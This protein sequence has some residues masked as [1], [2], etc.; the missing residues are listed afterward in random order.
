VTP[1]AVVDV[2][3][4]DF[5]D[6]ASTRRAA[7]DIDDRFA[8]VDVLIN[9]AG[10]HTMSQRTTVDGLPEMIA[11]N[12]LAPWLFTGTVL[13]A[14][15]RADAARVVTVASEASRRHGTLRIP[16]DLIN[17]EPFNALQSSQLYGKTKL[18]DIMFSLELATLLAD[19]AISAMC[20]NPG[21]NTTGLG[22]ELRF[23]APLERMLRKL[24]IG[25]PHNG[26]NLIVRI[27]TDTGLQSGGYYSG[28][29]ARSITPVAPAD[30]PK[31]RADLW[32]ATAELLAAKGHQHVY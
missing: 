23:A 32:Q 7:A 15:K 8:H 25:D 22:R 27:A 17:T 5:S 16:D 31:A 11:V 9:N 10:V 13:P 20:L 14:L 12:Y 29:S 2:V 24:R 26:A 6:L 21:F 4:A 19:T 28:K 1:D 3:D 30:D 18:L